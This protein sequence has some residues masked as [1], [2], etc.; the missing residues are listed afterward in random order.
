LRKHRH[1]FFHWS[2]PRA[3]VQVLI[4]RQTNWKTQQCTYYSI[5]MLGLGSDAPAFASAFSVSAVSSLDIGRYDYMC[6]LGMGRVRLFGT[7]PQIASPWM[8]GGKPPE[9]AGNVETNSRGMLLKIQGLPPHISQHTLMSTKALTACNTGTR[10]AVRPRFGFIPFVFTSCGSRFRRFQFM[11]RSGS[12][13]SGSR[14]VHGLEKHA[15]IPRKRRELCT[16]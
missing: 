9:L 15:D 13:G 1:I 7:C 8:C 14:R 3:R 16:R 11:T 2:I 4:K 6:T 5:H 10:E 12:D